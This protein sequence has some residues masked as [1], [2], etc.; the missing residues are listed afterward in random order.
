MKKKIS[1]DLKINLKG[2][3]KKTIINGWLNNWAHGFS[4]QGLKRN[5][6]CLLL[7]VF[8]KRLKFCTWYLV[9]IIIFKARENGTVLWSDP[10]PPNWRPAENCKRG[11]ETSLGNFQQFASVMAVLSMCVSEMEKTQE[12][13]LSL[14]KCH[15]T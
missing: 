14:F 7:N 5:T 10:T 13:Q 8:F 2:N 15:I 11:W 12:L 3:S 6:P 1:N 4:V 9:L